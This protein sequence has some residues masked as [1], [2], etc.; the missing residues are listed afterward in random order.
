MAAWA[1]RSS[2]TTAACASAR[3][4]TLV[5]ISSSPRPV[6]PRSVRAKKSIRDK[7]GIKDTIEDILITLSSQ[8]HLIRMVGRS[9]F[10]YVVL[11]RAKSNLALSRKELE[12]IEKQLD[13]ERG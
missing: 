7:L 10:F 6:T 2:T 4:A 9:M 11:D 3:W 5:S 13:I 1:P 12:A 8:Y